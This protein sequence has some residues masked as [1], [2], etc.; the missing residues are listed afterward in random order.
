MML[1][2]MPIAPVEDSHRIHAIDAVRGFAL[3]GILFV[4][5][6]YYS[7]PF[8]SATRTHAP[9]SAALVDKFAFNVI[10][11]FCESKF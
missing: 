11:I 3:L 5:V 4:N 6:L 9:A 7:Q 10:H 8:A 1:N 2:D